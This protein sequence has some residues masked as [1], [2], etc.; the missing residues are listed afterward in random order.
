MDDG[1]EWSLGGSAEVVG[2][3]ERRLLRLLSKTRGALHVGERIVVIDKDGQDQAVLELVARDTGGAWLV[4]L[5]STEPVLDFSRELGGF[6]T[7]I[8][9]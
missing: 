4:D 6:S 9:S 2:D 3:N 1:N 8:Y 5:C 7:W